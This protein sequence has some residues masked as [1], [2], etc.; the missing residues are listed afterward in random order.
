MPKK[1]E[2]VS[3][4]SLDREHGLGV[5]SGQLETLRGQLIE[6]LRRDRAELA[7]L[8]DARQPFPA[9]SSNDARLVRLAHSLHGVSA[10]FGY[11]QLGACAADL[12][13]AARE[14]IAGDAVAVADAQRV[15]RLLAALLAALDAAIGT[16]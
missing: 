4:D 14:A 12:E 3:G 7:R 11:L 1:T 10:S 15:D 2:P 8:H 6:R 5:L 16:S 9:G 13:T